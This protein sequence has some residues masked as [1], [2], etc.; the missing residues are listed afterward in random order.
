[1][2]KQR[3]Q[4]NDKLPKFPE[5]EGGPVY[6]ESKIKTLSLLHSVDY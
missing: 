6:R 4:N 2:K 1:M 5:E 3:T